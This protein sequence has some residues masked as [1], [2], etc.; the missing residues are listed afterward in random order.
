[1]SAPGLGSVPGYGCRVRCLGLLLFAA[2]AGAPP[3]PS[4][5]VSGLRFT[6][7][8][9]PVLG[10]DGTGSYYR[11]AA[12]IVEVEP[13]TRVA[14]TCANAKSGEIRDHLFLRSA[15]REA[16]A[17][18]WGPESLA[19]APARTATGSCDGFD[20]YHVCD[21]EI[22]AGAFRYEGADYRWALFYGGNDV[23][24]SAHNAIGVAL[25]KTPTGPFVRV[26]TP[27]VPYSVACDDGPPFSW[28]AGQPSVVGLG[29]GRLHLF[30][31]ADCRGKSRALRF[32][33][34]LSDFGVATP[35]RVSAPMLVP[36]EGLTAGAPRSGAPDSTLNNASFLWDRA[37][38]RFFVVRSQHPMP[39]DEPRS[40]SRVVEIAVI[41]GEGLRTGK[42]R[43][44]P[45]GHLGPSSDD[46]NTYPTM[47]PR[48]HSAGLVRDPMGGLLDERRLEIALTTNGDGPF[49]G[50]LWTKKVHVIEA[51]LAAP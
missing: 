48:N 37:R 8:S 34:D 28:G 41:D 25:A 43:F 36:V 39:T 4:A 33:V 5:T 40:T 15:H 23:D 9:M 45:L 21:P 16:A 30:V 13:D 51:T 2:C 18:R 31:R 6:T 44:R 14:F 19:L 42:G 47:A 49:P 1:M 17:W 29:G 11:Y 12:S 22:V 7:E 10:A 50:W 27:I 38:D 24:R 26:P 3:S 32:D 46:A 20:C 35:P